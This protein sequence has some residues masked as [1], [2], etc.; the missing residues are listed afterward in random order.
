MSTSSLLTPPANTSWRFFD[1]KKNLLYDRHVRPCA[2]G[3]LF[4]LGV[5][6]RLRYLGAIVV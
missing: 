2:A 1:S 6:S 3:V 4:F 5:S